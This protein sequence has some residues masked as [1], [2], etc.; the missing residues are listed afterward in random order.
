MPFAQAVAPTTARS[1]LAPAEMPD[2]VPMVHQ[3]RAQNK[4][5][6]TIQTR[7]ALCATTSAILLGG[8]ALAQD[9]P[10]S[11][12]PAT[13]EYSPYPGQDFPNQVL[14]GDTHLHT[15]FS[16]DAGLVGATLTPDDAYR[17]ARGEEVVSSTG[18]PARLARPLDFLV[19]T[20]HAENLGLPVAMAERSPVLMATDWGQE[21]V[22][23]TAPGTT[24]SMIAGYELWMARINAVDDPLDGTDFARTMWERVTQAAEA[25]N[26]PGAFSAMIGFEWTL[27]PAG[28]NLHRNVIFRDGKALGLAGDVRA[29]D[30]RARARDP[31]QRQSV[32]RP[33]VRRRDPGRENTHRPGLCPAPDALGAGLRG[34]PDQG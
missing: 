15:A 18:V 26:V 19:V 30:R 8:V 33:D 31:A 17:F 20:D 29:D 27:T 10:S 4:E 12:P 23:T 28:N 34:D 16:A 5:G 2:E 1:R 25:H 9:A 3:Q 7:A 32:E 21:I 14:F 24:E 22:A 6:R 13:A 11:A